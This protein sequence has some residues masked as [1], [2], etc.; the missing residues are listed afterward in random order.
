MKTTLIFL[1]LILNSIFTFSQ[2]FGDTIVSNNPSK[3]KVKVYYFH[4][5][6]R[7]HT[8]YSIEANVR[9]TLLENFKTE[10]NNGT[11]DLYILNSDKIENLTLVKKYEA[12]GSTLAITVYDN[13]KELQT[14]DL[15]NW[16]FQKASKPDDFVKELKVKL[17][18]IIKK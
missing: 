3:T 17:T 16:A 13:S 15:S 14:E 18:D 12:Y 2:H 10:L 11:I 7:C 6:E 1:M 4:I 9:K 5:T 8:C